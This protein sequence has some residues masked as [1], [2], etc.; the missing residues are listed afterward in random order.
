MLCNTYPP[1]G[2]AIRRLYM[3]QGLKFKCFYQFIGSLLRIGNLIDLRVLNFSKIRLF[4]WA[5]SSA[6]IGQYKKFALRKRRNN[7]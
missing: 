5:N 1:K 7:E 3:T 4:T 6:L 2:N